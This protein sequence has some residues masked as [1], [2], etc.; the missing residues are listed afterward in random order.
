MIVHY[1]KIA[2]RN[3]LKNKT[4]TLISILGLS[5][6]LLCFSICLYCTRYIYNT[7]R[8]FENRHRLVQMATMDKESGESMGITYSDF[9]EEL[10][11]LSLPEVE[12]YIY[13]DLINP[14]FFNVEVA[15]NKVLPY[16]LQC[17][18]TEASYFQAFTPE[19]IAGSWKQA[20]YT[21]NSLILTESM[22]K[23]IFG[24]TEKAVG[25]Q[26][27]LAQKLISSPQ[28]TPFSG[29][30]SYTVQAVA[31]DLPE[32]NSLNFLQQTDA[33]VLND[34]EGII[35]CEFKRSMAN[36]YTYALLKEGVSCEDFI[37]KT[38]ALK[39]TYDFF[40]SEQYLFARPF[41]QLF[42]ETSSASTCALTT[43]V[44]GILILLV[45]MLNFFYFLT[46]S[47]ITRIREYCLRQVN[48]A[49]VYQIWMMLA[50][51]TTLS[52]FFAGLFTMVMME[53][54]A[55]HLSFDLDFFQH[56]I[57]PIVLMKQASTY[58][59][60]LWVCCLLAAWLVVYRVKR[61]SILQG[62][63]GGSG[64]SGR[65]RT[66][67]ILL[68]I[69]FFICWIFFSCTVGLY[70][71]SQKTGNAI[72]NTLT[73]EEKD[74]IFS[75]SFTSYTFLNKDERNQLVAEFRNIA[76]VKNVLPA[77]RPYTSGVPR[78][79]IYLTPDRKQG[80]AIKVN[81]VYAVPE[82]F[83]FMNIPLQAGTAHRNLNEMV[84]SRNLEEYL[85]KEMLGENLYN[86]QGNTFTVTG[87]CPPVT[88]SVH[89]LGNINSNEAHNY[90]Y[91]PIDTDKS[92]Y[93]CYVKC[94]PGQKKKVG[95]ALETIV[96]NRLP[97]SVDFE[98][99][100]LWDDI[101]ERQSLEFQLRGIVGFF[102]FVTLII[103]LLGVYSAITLD[104][105]YRRKEVAIRKIN[106]AG[107]KD[108]V[109]L[110]ARLYTFMLVITAL[111]AFPIVLWLEQKFGQM[112]T[113]SV[114]MGFGFFAC[115]FLC[116]VLVVCL[117][118][119]FRI[120]R[121]TRINPAEIIKKE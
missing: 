97:E 117:T 18:E 4:Q 27:T 84:V 1:L 55:P 85:N 17:M 39:Q 19:V 12:S 89:S 15:D 99:H 64:V 106:G 11:K 57:N 87:I 34:S 73:V 9:G 8:C 80:T 120:Y 50:I 78:T 68:G 7:N 51:Q 113:V 32:N 109:L 116:I 101:R 25:K 23:R 2:V 58:L 3:L 108:I 111:L 79:S 104:T 28:T 75:I 62:I 86:Y 118:V 88:C 71:L 81:L 115:V 105:E 107:M 65:H 43:F 110:F 83:E 96:R 61:I 92:T 42:W 72:L 44:A 82:F 119:G 14:R 76:G 112:Y 95:K 22:A 53:I 10:K 91:F 31:K 45:G 114:D 41:D 121:T 54:L 90:I 29:G 13:V 30:I 46:G 100:T 49:K 35:A 38:N 47:Y 98:L 102:A 24:Q 77:H 33:W 63:M 6:A 74:E 67:N 26:M 66:R 37:R 69:Q 103:V 36:G 40:E 94:E 16:T 5:V 21:P 93:Q 52:V 70:L 20:T 56:T 59:F 48:G 60:A